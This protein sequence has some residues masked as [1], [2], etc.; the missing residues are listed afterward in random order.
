[1]PPYRSTTAE[2]APT[3]VGGGPGPHHIRRI[4]P[5]E[6]ATDAAKS[7]YS[8][9]RRARRVDLDGDIQTRAVK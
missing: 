8:F 7:H 6:E 3:V 5:L 1:M 2:F 4:P 9:E